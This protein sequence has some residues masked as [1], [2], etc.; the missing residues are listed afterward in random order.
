[1]RAA[2][3]HVCLAL[4]PTL[5]L[6][7]ASP[8]VR[9]AL[10]QSAPDPAPAAAP[11]PAR[12]P[13]P[14]RAQID[15]ALSR[16]VEFLISMQEPDPA[17]RAPSAPASP[18][19]P[20]P[21]RSGIKNQ[22]PYEGVY[23]V[24][25]QIPVGYRI[26]GTSICAMA[27]IRAPGF[28]END[29]AR[30]AVERAADF[31]V[32]ALDHP[33][34]NPDYEGGYDVRGWGYT[35]ALHLLLVL[36]DPTRPMMPEKWKGSPRC[37]DAINRC[38]KAIQQTEIAQVGGWNYA[39]AAGKDAVSPPSPFMTGPTLQA[40]FEARRQGFT[41][42]QQVVERALDALD[43]ARTR[44]GS[45]VYS[46]VDGST[47]REAVPGSVGRMLVSETTLYLAGRSSLERVR[48]SVDAFFTHW[49]WLEKRRAQ[50]GT[51]VAPYGVAPYY[52]FYAHYYAAQAI[53]QLPAIDRP[54]YR[55]RLAKAL[56]LVRAE[57]NAEQG[58]G[59]AGGVGGGWNDRVFDRSANFGTAMAMM[60]LGMDKSPRP[61][62]WEAG[63]VAPADG[64]KSTP[65]GDSSTPGTS[66]K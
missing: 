2:P 45:F 33:L 65:K 49:E 66:E 3:L 8:S 62:R 44:S 57:E 7:V 23:R 59:K 28:A 40:L 43:Q 35:Y 4:I 15:Q 38:I 55:R 6:G 21:A 46:G 36:N 51:H 52:F 19:S 63:N 34:M 9:V 31:V 42:D 5:S 24:Q 22:W 30:Q 14:T 17:S 60:A 58:E 10:A 48:G 16:G 27:L 41:V 54:E 25:R 13:D 32:D 56:F 18:S 50:P 26:G 64:P 12:Q 37:A 53:E 61:A 1:M 29:D 11:T 39:R 47:S 20:A